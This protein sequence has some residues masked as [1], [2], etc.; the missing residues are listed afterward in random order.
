MG[1]LSPKAG[2]SRSAA[3]AK[4][5]GFTSSSIE[6]GYIDVYPFPEAP[7]TAGTIMWKVDQGEGFFEGAT[8]AILPTSSS[9]SPS[10]V[11]K[12]S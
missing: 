2:R 3:P 10:R 5:T 6:V 8:G 12:E 9:T 4:A 1:R 11:M 7:Y